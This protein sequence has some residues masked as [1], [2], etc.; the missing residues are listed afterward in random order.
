MGA[1]RHDG[2]R[3]IGGAMEDEVTAILSAVEQ[4]DPLP[5]GR[6]L[7]LIYDELRVL[8]AQ[9]LAH[10][11]PGQTLQATALVHEA[12]L[13]LVDTGK[14]RGPMERPCGA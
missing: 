2:S 10:E 5:A 3:A 6:L 14:R 8:A 13:R 1:I 12:Y 4:G 9:R 7:P 11:K